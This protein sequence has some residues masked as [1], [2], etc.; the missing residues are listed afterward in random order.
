VTEQ[1]G[2]ELLAG[3]RVA[4]TIVIAS[5]IDPWAKLAPHQNLRLSLDPRGLHFFDRESGEA[6]R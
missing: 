6:L 3:V 2:A 1:L 5:R 4:G